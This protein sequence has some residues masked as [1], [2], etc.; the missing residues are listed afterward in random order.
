[1]SEIIIILRY[2]II[3]ELFHP[4]ETFTVKLDDCYTC[5]IAWLYKDA[6]LFG[7][8]NYKNLI[9]TNNV[10]CPGSIGPVLESTDPGFIALMDECPCKFASF[11]P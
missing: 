4:S 7:I 2:Q 6:K 8:D 10:I 5:D 9:G 1:M 11:Y 3:S